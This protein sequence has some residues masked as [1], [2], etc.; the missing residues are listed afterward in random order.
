MPC[1]LTNSNIHLP[2]AKGQRLEEGERL[3][4]SAFSVYSRPWDVTSRTASVDRSSI[5]I[6][7]RRRASAPVSGLGS[8][9]GPR[10]PPSAGPLPGNPTALAAAPA[11][12][13]LLI[14]FARFLGKLPSSFVQPF[15]YFMTVL[16]IYRVVVFRSV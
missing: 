1:A 4:E 8:G 9:V 12:A 10:A 5:G 2:G 3:A 14:P 6:A 7:F 11:G 13:Q 15:N 16:S